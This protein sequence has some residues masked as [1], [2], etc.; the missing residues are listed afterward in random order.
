MKRLRFVRPNQKIGFYMCGE[1]GETTVRP[2][3]HAI[4]FN[5]RFEDQRFYKW[6]TNG[7]PIYKS[8]ELNRLWKLGEC[9]VGAVTFE[10]AAY[11]ARYILK[12]ITGDLAPAHYAGRAP[13]Y[14]Q[15]SRASGIG[16]GWFEKYKS[17]CYPSDFL[18]HDGKKA[19]VPRYYDKQ[20]PEEE[21]A[22]YKT[23]RKETA[24]LTWKNS[25]PSRLRVRETVKKSQMALIK[26]DFK[27][28]Y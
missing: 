3:Y 28:D 8:E 23:S 5:T 7:D 1:Y 13:E 24:R 11:V 17:D 22:T 9:L 15:M 20:L 10:S 21:L 12:K 27:N 2:H 18:V 25:T 14:A 16:K 6:S 19:K 4:L 26:R